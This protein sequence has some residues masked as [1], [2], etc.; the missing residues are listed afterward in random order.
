MRYRKSLSFSVVSAGEVDAGEIITTPPG[1][2][3]DCATA[4]VT[5]DE[6][7]PTIP[8]TP[9]TFTNALAASVAIC[10]LVPESR[11][12]T[13]SSA[14]FTPPA[15]F[16]SSTAKSTALCIGGPNVAK[17]PVAS[18][19]VPICTVPPASTI[20]EPA[21]A[22]RLIVSPGLTNWPVEVTS[23]STTRQTSIVLSTSP[24][25]SKSWLPAAP[26]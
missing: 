8:P 24:C 7:E 12:T 11:C 17:S 23:P 26:T 18:S 21:S 1:I 13:C 20:A 5:P 2:V 22:G 6:S 19:S 4:S 15:S 16:T 9:S 3:C 10:S 25:A 14:P